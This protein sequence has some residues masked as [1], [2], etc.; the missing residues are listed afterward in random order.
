MSIEKRKD[1]DFNS[2]SDLVSLLDLSE[3]SGVPLEFIK[4]ELFLTEKEIQMCVL[5]KSMLEF[6]D[7]KMSIS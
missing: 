6:V 3:I 7:R 2:D 1:S 5:R 4:K